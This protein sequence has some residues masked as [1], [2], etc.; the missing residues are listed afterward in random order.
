MDN[1]MILS[2]EGWH[3][4]QEDKA[5]GV[6]EHRKHRLWKIRAV[7]Y[8]E[9]SDFLLSSPYLFVEARSRK[10]AR[11]KVFKLAKFLGSK[12]T[13]ELRITEVKPEPELSGRMPCFNTLDA[14]SRLKE[15][16]KDKEES[17][18]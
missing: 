15:L 16:G 12:L 3:R 14:M 13:F 4:H 6:E 11:S 2:D 17:M 10:E 5:M 7:Y 18:E 1:P 8:A 9:V